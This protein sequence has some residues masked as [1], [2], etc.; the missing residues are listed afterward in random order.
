M[1]QERASQDDLGYRI[2]TVTFDLQTLNALMREEGSDEAKVFNLVR[3]LRGEVEN[4]PEMAPTLIPLKKLAEHILKDME[5]RTT[6]GLAAMDLLV[7]LAKEKEASEKAAKD[8][9][10]SKRA[11]GVYSTLKDDPDLRAAE[12]NEMA[13]ARESEALLGR[14]PNAAVSAR[15]GAAATDKSVP[16]PLGASGRGAEPGRRARA[17]SLAGDRY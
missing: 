13:L 1:V 14:F 8:S 3:G 6:T 16:A 17:G 12:V 11:F 9:G 2:K 4:D 10:L 15:R 5:E 7:T